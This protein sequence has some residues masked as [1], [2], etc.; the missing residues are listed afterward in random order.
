MQQFIILTLKQCIRTLLIFL[1]IVIMIIFISNLSKIYDLFC[2]LLND[3]TLQLIKKMIV[4]SS[5]CNVAIAK[6]SMCLKGRQVVFQL[7]HFQMDTKN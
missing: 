4:E 3:S 1:V 5:F 2:T 7:I 6:T